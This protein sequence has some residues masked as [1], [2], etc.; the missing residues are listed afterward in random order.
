[1]ADTPASY[2]AGGFKERVGGAKR[3]CRHCMATFEDMQRY[4]TEE[5]FHQRNI[6]EHE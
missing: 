1:M 6:D 5:D 2:K 4:F 3:K